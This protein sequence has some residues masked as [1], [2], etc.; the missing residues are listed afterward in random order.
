M[1]K[2]STAVLTNK[3]NEVLILKRSKK[4]RTYRELWSGVSGYVEENEKPYETAI[5]EIKEETGLKKKDIKLIKKLKVIKF[6]DIYRNEKYNWEL[7]PFVFLTEKKDKI[8]IDWEHTEYRW[9]K[10]SEIENIQTVPH[11]K[12]IIIMCFK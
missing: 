4:V 3:K 9:I 5:K 12:D 2:V 10:P 1:T 8:N 7:Y 6:T 11:F